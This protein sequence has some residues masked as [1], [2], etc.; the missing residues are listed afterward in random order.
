MAGK[1]FS[2]R[3]GKNETKL[4]ASD[5]RSAGHDAWAV[6]MSLNANPHSSNPRLSSWWSE[7]WDM[8]MNAA[9]ADAWKLGEEASRNGKTLDDNPFPAGEPL[10]RR[11]WGEGWQ[12]GQDAHIDN[13]PRGK[14]R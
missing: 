11:L 5:I 2:R 9:T 1:V 12:S 3:G 13:S 14:R 10:A 4:T 8:A 6:G 7:G